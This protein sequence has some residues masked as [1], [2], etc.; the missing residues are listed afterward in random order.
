M[1]VIAALSDEVSIMVS[2]VEVVQMLIKICSEKLKI[3][4]I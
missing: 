2:R 3:L 1:V 4:V